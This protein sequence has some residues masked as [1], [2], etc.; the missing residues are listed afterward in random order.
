MKCQSIE[1]PPTRRSPPQLAA[2]QPVAALELLDRGA[3]A[4]ARPGGAIDAGLALAVRLAGP[5]GDVADQAAA[6]AT[7][8]LS[9]GVGRLPFG[10]GGLRRGFG[11]GADGRLLRSRLPLSAA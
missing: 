4:R 3:G 5:P 1:P 2:Q 6:L 8:P 11:P 9:G 7:Q 10:F